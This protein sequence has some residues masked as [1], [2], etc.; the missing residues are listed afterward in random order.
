LAYEYASNGRRLARIDPGRARA[1]VEQ[2]AG[3]GAQSHA[4]HPEFIAG[5]AAGLAEANEY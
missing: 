5:C 1:L 4:P 2:Y 3:A